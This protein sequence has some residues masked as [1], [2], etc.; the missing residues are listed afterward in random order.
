MTDLGQLREKLAERSQRVTWLPVGSPGV[1]TQWR[2]RSSPRRRVARLAYA[3]ATI[4]TVLGGFFALSAGATT[5][6]ISTTSYRV[7]ASVLHAQSDGSFVGDGALMIMPEQNGIVRAGASIVVDGT[8]ETGVC[9]LSKSQRQER[10]LFSANA[11]SISAVDTWTGSGWSRR[12][13]DG[14]QVTI[15]SNALAPVPFEVGR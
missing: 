10:C 5:V 8:T 4:L 14:K 11:S 1:T 12:Y 7:G 15:D 3:V 2:P 6:S 13:D 9:F